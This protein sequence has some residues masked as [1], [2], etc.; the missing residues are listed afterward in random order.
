MF[1]G[2]FIRHLWLWIILMCKSH[3]FQLMKWKLRPWAFV[4]H[5]AHLKSCFLGICMCLNVAPSWDWLALLQCFS[6]E[7]SRDNTWKD[8]WRIIMRPVFT[9]NTV[10]AKGYH[11][12]DKD[13]T[14]TSFLI[15]MNCFL[16]AFKMDRKYKRIWEFSFSNSS[17][18]F[19]SSY[20]QKIWLKFLNSGLVIPVGIQKQYFV[21]KRTLLIQ[22]TKAVAVLWHSRG[23]E[24]WISTCNVSEREIDRKTI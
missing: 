20:F 6:W 2:I 21:A 11:Y 9:K 7:E 19:I 8:F 18:V 16:W 10:R 3:F 22:T 13:T 23:S 1:C 4:S 15:K 24:T 12:R 5:P 17:C 14:R